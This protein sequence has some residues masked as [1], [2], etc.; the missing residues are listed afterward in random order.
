MVTKPSSDVFGGTCGARAWGSAAGIFAFCGPGTG[1]CVATEF[2]AGSAFVTSSPVE[3]LS[4]SGTSGRSDG[5][6]TEGLRSE[7]SFLPSFF[8]FPRKSQS[9]SPFETPVS[10][11]PGGTADISRE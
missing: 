11:S 5:N 7:L 10:I 2:D 4:F 8:D 3:A 1:V 9:T 6:E